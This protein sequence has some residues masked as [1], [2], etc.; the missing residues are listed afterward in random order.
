M[1]GRSSTE[2]VI[3]CIEARVY[4]FKKGRIIKVSNTTYT[5]D[6]DITLEEGRG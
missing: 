3:I 5:F 1:K 4:Y 6:N 2:K